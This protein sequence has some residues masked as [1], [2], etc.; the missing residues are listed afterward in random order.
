MNTG[1]VMTQHTFS[2]VLAGL[3][4]AFTLAFTLAIVLATP[5][6]AGPGHD[7]GD[8]PAAS[9]AA[10]S[11][12]FEAVS[13]L[14]ELVGILEGRHL[15]LYLDRA[16]DNR[17]VEGARLEVDFGNTRLTLTDRGG[18]IFDAELGTP[19]APG[20]T[21]ITVTVVAGAQSDLLAGELEL[22]ADHEAHDTDGPG[23]LARHGRSAGI[24][25]AAL[26][27][28]TV[29]AVAA[30]RLARRVRTGSPS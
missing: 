25:A 13:D 29:L 14:F 21:P 16:D 15:T 19:P 18:G 30:R 26:V 5:A 28:L 11:P 2:R 22:H 24:A 10:A 6:H 1:H 4:H 9:P 3:V 27:V 20:V 12:R 8:A 7:H 23:L 17:P